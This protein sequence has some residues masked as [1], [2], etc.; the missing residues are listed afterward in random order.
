[1][2]VRLSKEQER[3]IKEML[4]MSEISDEKV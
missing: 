4:L 1:M 2:V 3:Q